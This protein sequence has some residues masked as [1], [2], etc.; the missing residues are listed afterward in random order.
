M[1]SA[2]EERWEHV[3]REPVAGDPAPRETAPDTYRPAAPFYDPR[4]ER[5]IWF[6]D[7]VVCSL[8]AIRFFMKLLGASYQADFVRFIYGVT[9]PLVAPFR[10]IFQSSGSG[11]YVLEPESLIAIAIY[12]L[13]GWGLVALIRI[14]STPRPRQVV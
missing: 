13:I 9:G 12:L 1:R 3:K 8:V 5:V 6:L 4:P 11:N 7:A 14:L 10:G 2:E